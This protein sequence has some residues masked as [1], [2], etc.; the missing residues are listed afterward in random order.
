MYDDVFSDGV[1]AEPELAQSAEPATTVADAPDAFEGNESSPVVADVPEPTEQAEATAPAEGDQDTQGKEE[2]QQPS[3]DELEKL[4]KEVEASLSDPRTPKWFKNAVESV[5][6]PKLGSLGT[7]V[8]QYS[9]LGT[10]DEIKER[11]GLLDKLGEITTDPQT[12]MPIKSTQGFVQAI[13]EKDP[14]LSQQLMADLAV[15]P[16]PDGSGQTVIQALFS[17]L[18]I[19]PN[20]LADVQQFAQNGYQMQMAEFAPPDP[21]D[22]AEIPQHLQSTFSKLAPEMRDSLMSDV[23]YVR[24]QN[25]EAHKYRI[26]VEERDKAQKAQETQQL[27]QAQQRQ[28]AEFVEKVDTKS[29]EYFEKSGESVL[30]MFVESLS[31]Q[32]GMTPLDAL[33]VSN[34]MLNA[35]EPT[36]AGRKTF[37]ALKKV[38]IEIDPAIPIAIDQLRTLSRHGAYYELVGDKESVKNVVADIAEIQERISAKGNKVI[39]TL[40][41]MRNGN[42]LKKVVEGNTALEKTNTDR[43]AFSGDP[44]SGANLDRN[45][46]RQP[47]DFSDEAYIEDLRASGFR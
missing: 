37:E 1:G 2:A 16:A 41:K 46:A 9:A 4:E 23:D 11:I 29:E 20:R 28:Q 7:Q 24:N 44:L 13:Y 26:D 35:L 17:N 32:A 6:K 15:L 42:N 18:G 25:L 27:Q 39:A 5:Y 33:M 3:E 31:K 34:T 10:P 47:T 45:N 30:T 43:H 40:A 14:E 8:E 36:L 12:R 21:A 19:D 22:L 38:G